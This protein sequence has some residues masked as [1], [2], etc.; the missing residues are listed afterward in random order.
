M[1]EGVPDIR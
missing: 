1:R